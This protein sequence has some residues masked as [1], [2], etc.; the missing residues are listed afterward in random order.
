MNDVQ[1]GPDQTL[2]ESIEYWRENYR[3][4]VEVG[5]EKVNALHACEPILE[6]ANA[7]YDAYRDP[8]LTAEQVGEFARAVIEAVRQDRLQPRRS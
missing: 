1:Q 7:Y 5:Q 2:T 8:A 3:K 6:A 4:A